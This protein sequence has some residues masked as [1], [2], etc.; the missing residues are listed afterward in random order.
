MLTCYIIP[1]FLMLIFG[2]F[3]LILNFVNVS[4]FLIANILTSAIFYI[5]LIC[6][7][8]NLILLSFLIL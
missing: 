5:F 3:S 4:V 6:I 7:N 1:I 8:V 2:L